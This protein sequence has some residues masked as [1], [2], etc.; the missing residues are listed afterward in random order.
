MVICEHILGDFEMVDLDVTSSAKMQGLNHRSKRQVGLGSLSELR[1]LFEELGS[2]SRE[3]QESQKKLDNLLS[4][5]SGS[6]KKGINSLI[7][8]VGDLQAKNSVIA[9][10]RDGLL[11]TFNKMRVEEIQHRTIQFPIDKVFPKAKENSNH[12]VDCRDSDILKL[13]LPEEDEGESEEKDHFQITFENHDENGFDQAMPQENSPQLDHCIDK[14][15]DEDVK[16]ID[17]AVVEEQVTKDQSDISEHEQEETEIK[18]KRRKPYKSKQSKAT[19]INTRNLKQHKNPIQKEGQGSPKTNYDGFKNKP[20]RISAIHGAEREK[21]KQKSNPARKTKDVALQDFKQSLGN[22]LQN[23]RFIKGGLGKQLGCDQC[24][25]ETSLKEH[26]LQHIRVHNDARIK[27]GFGKTLMCD[28]CPYE[29]SHKGHFLQHSRVHNDTRNHLC[30]KCPF[31]AKTKDTLKYHI[32]AVHENI[33]DLV[34][35]ECG[36]ATSRPSALSEH[37]QTVHNTGE[38]EFSCDQCPYRAYMKKILM[39]HVKNVHVGREYQF[40]CEQCNF[41]S[42]SQGNLTTH[43]LKVHK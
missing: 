42:N 11:L 34:C 15:R 14:F 5:Y 17:H 12:E 7:E 38:K 18:K 26:Y 25:Y 23:E 40:K 3:R 20:L 8:E 36:Y 28:Q 33:R 31:K 6:I 21:S 2:W 10:E 24:P 39:K 27:G 35:D 29:S 32:K 13:E 1:Y 16:T 41:K 4:S 43:I 22:K 30:E 19:H 9:K 37:K